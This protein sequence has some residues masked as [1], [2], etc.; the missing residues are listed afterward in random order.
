[1]QIVLSVSHIRGYV[2][3]C[4]CWTGAMT[5]VIGLSCEAPSHVNLCFVFMA[6]GELPLRSFSLV[7][8]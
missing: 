1:M 2:G 7:T 6:I 3:R 5:G 4:R 8:S